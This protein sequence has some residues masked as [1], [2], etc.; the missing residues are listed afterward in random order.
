MSSSGKGGTTTQTTDTGSAIPDWLTAGSQN[1][2]QTATDLSNRPYTP[3]TGEQVAQPTADTQQAYQQVRDMQGAQAPAFDASKAAWSGLLPSAAPIT[4]AGVN[5]N[6]TRSRQLP[7]E[8]DPA[9]SA[10]PAGRLPRRPGDRLR[11]RRRAGGADV[12][13]RLR[14]HRP[15]AGGRRT[16]APDRPPDGRRQRQPRGGLRRLAAGGRR[17]RVRRPDRARDTGPDRPDADHRPGSGAHSGDQPRAAG[18]PGGLRRAA[19]TLAGLLGSGY[20]AA[21]T[22]SG[23]IAGANQGAGIT[24]A[25][26]LPITATAQQKL[27]QLDGRRCK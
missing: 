21:A 26:Q 4:A 13:V 14:A 1:A 10:P 25:Q 5:D 2:V 22:E 24:A 7:A 9:C 12:A 18:G 17:G 3:Y 23:S 16:G 6:T 27:D 15:D 11:R 20:G 19:G 8:R